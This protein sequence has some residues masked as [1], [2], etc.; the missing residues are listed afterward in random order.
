MSETEP[1]KYGPTVEDNMR[2]IMNVRYQLLPY[3]YAQAWQVTQNGAAMMRPLVMDFASD[4]TAMKQP[5]EFMFGS[6]FLVSPVLEPG[7]KDWNVYLP[8]SNNWYNFW[9]NEMY[10]GGQ[11]ITTD[12][13]LDKIPLFVKAGSIV[14]VGPNVQYAT[15]SNNESLEIRIYEGADGEFILYEDEGDNYNYEKG[16]YTTI[17]FGWNDA[18]KTLRIGYR[19]GLFQGMITNREFKIHL[20]SK[21]KNAGAVVGETF[22]KIVPYSGKETIVKIQ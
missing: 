9:T 15:Q 11:T 13:P 20:I 12:A 5:Y 16:D 7:K 3:I 14:P 18:D 10:S 22:D 4:T 8:A 1:W 2:K 6:A 17:T 19:I 21:G